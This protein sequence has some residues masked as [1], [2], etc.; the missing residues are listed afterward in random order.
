MHLRMNTARNERL[1]KAGITTVRPSKT[2]LATLGANEP[3]VV[4]ARG[5]GRGRGWSSRALRRFRSL[6]GL[7]RLR[8]SRSG[9][10]GSGRGSGGGRAGPGLAALGRLS[11]LPPDHRLVSDVA[12]SVLNVTGGERVHGDG[13]E[14]GREKSERGERNEVEE[15]ASGHHDC[16]ERMK[17]GDREDCV[18]RSV[19]A[20]E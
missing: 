7:G 12:M 18:L 10:V 17:R 3:V 14:R 2:E 11:A 15:L 16:S 4:T 1:E 6:R 9:L 8:G 20:K 5:R 19:V 13:A